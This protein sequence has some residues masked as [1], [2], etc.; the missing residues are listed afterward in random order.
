MTDGFAPVE[1][2]IPN[3]GAAG[4]RRRLRFGVAGWIVAGAGLLYL[5]AV[6]A[7]RAWRF[8]LVLPFWA[9]AIGFFQ[10]REKT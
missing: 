6:D 3:I 10:H 7:D 1:A 9:G 5:L 2:C 4:R 8:L